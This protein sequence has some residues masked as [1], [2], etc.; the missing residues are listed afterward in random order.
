MTRNR[1]LMTFGQR[2]KRA[3]GIWWDLINTGTVVFALSV[4]F[5]GFSVILIA[6]RTDL[7][8]FRDT[9]WRQFLE[10]VPNEKQTEIGISV[11]SVSV[12]AA[13][14]AA[15]YL[16]RVGTSRWANNRRIGHIHAY[17]AEAIMSRCGY[18]DCSDADLRP[19]LKGFLNSSMSV[20]EQ[21][22][23][24]HGTA[25]VFF[26]H[27]RMK[28]HVALSGVECMVT[29]ARDIALDLYAAA[30]ICQR[31]VTVP[32]TFEG[33]DATMRTRLQERF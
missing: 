21:I 20:F 15:L 17:F 8:P 10:I 24:T 7:L 32:E 22:S 13:S 16:I 28:T 2:L 6:G 30:L 3:Y 25:Q 4:V 18:G 11:L 9:L 27:A 33:F 14:A 5:I 26:E 19:I 23:E 12:S 29:Q 1:I 31:A